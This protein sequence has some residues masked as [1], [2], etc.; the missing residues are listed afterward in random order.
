MAGSERIE[1]R[2]ASFPAFE[3]ELLPWLHQA[4]LVFLALDSCLALDC[5]LGSQDSL[6]VRE[7]NLCASVAEWQRTTGIDGFMADK[8]RPSTE[9]LIIWLHADATAEPVVRENRRSRLAAAI[10]S[11]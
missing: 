3:R 2:A 9:S 10:A 7:S 4:N 11:G 5:G 1:V 6:G 8:A